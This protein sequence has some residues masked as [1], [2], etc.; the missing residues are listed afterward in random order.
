MIV[1]LYI[2]KSILCSGLFYGYYLIILRNKPF[3]Q[4]NRY[5]ILAT[6]MLSV[7]LPLV[8]VPIV[9]VAQPSNESFIKT[10]SVISMGGWEDEFIITAQTSF[11]WSLVT[12]QNVL[13][14]IY[15]T[16]FIIFIAPVIKSFLFITSINSK[17]A[18]GFIDRVAFYNTAE[19]G[20]P[21]SFFYAI[22]WNRSISLKSEEGQYILRHELFHIREKHSY[23]IVFM[24]CITAI[25]WFNPFF[26][27]MKM[28][29]QTI[30]EFL[31]DR[32]ATGRSDK[33]RYAQLLVL[34]A[35][36]KKQITIANQFFHNQ[37]K[38][39]V[40]MLTTNT[41]RYNYL[42]KIM[43]LPLLFVIFCAFTLN[44]QQ[45]S[46]AGM[47]RKTLQ[48]DTLPATTLAKMNP[49]DTVRVDVN[50]NV[51]VFRLRNGD[52][53]IT[54]LKELKALDKKSK[55]ERSS[56]QA[57]IF[58]KLEAEA[59]YPGG[60]EGW[61]AYLNKSLQYPRE[62]AAKS[63]EGTVIV[64]FIVDQAGD[65]RNVQAIS[66]PTDGGLREEAIRVVK[67]SGKWIPGKQNGISVKSYRKQ[68]LTF[69][70]SGKSI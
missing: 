10:F 6:T 67:N 49:G 15:V 7:V 36:Q 23:D 22:Y 2:L 38:R 1:L 26:H 21:F 59:A 64:Q 47:L 24:Q 19:P 4:Y 14:C 27:L 66:G 11:L 13:L 16:G 9:F 54:S 37:I 58:T 33:Y 70:V 20:T 40:T 55:D 43:A 45:R 25:C 68:P 35:M 46:D 31:A 28:E 52:S 42:D 65:L 61:S 62:A 48:T 30:H 17:Y 39:R 53:I 41:N 32:Y 50:K 34:H 5:Y 56:D 8:S 29:L 44:V 3:H 51:V 18:R 63:I 12:M 57:P 69:K 60:H